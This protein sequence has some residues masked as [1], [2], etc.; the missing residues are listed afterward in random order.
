MSFDYA[1]D[2]FEQSLKFVM[3]KKI[4]AV[5]RKSKLKEK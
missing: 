5:R 4:M 3:L 2:N 1:E